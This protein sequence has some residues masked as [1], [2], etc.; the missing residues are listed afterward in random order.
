[1]WVHPI[2]FKSDAFSTFQ[3]FQAR[4]ENETGHTIQNGR[5]KRLNETILTGM[6]CMLIEAG[7]S[8]KWWAEAAL[9]YAYIKNQSPHSAIGDAVPEHMYT[10][11]PPDVSHLRVFGCAA[12]VTILR[13]ARHKLEAPGVKMVHLGRNDKHKG[14][15]FWDP[16]TGKVHVTCDVHQWDEDK[17]PLKVEGACVPVLPLTAKL[18]GPNPVLARPLNAAAPAPA[19]T[20]TPL[21]SLTPDQT[22]AP[23]P[24]SHSPAAPPRRPRTES[25]SSDGS[26][27]VLSPTHAPRARPAEPVTPS[28]SPSMSPAP[29]DESPDPLM[30]STA[31]AD[32]AHNDTD[33]SG[34]AQAGDP[35]NYTEAMRSDLAGQWQQCADDKF[36][37]LRDKFNVFQT[38]DACS[39]PPTAKLLGSKWV[40]KTKPDETGS[41]TKYKARLV[42]LGCHQRN[43]IDYKETFALVAQFASICLLIAL[44]ASQGWPIIQADVDKA[45]LHGDLDKDLYLRIPQGVHGLQGKVLKLQRSLYGHSLATNASIVVGT[46]LYYIALYVDNLL[47]IGPDRPHI[48]RVLDG[49]E[50]EYGIKRLGDAKYILGIQVLRGVDGSV[51]LSQ[52]AYANSL[53]ERFQM[54][55]AHPTRIPMDAGLKLAQA[56]CPINP[57]VETEYRQMVGLLGYLAMGTRGEI[58]HAVGY[59]GRFFTCCNE[60]H[61]TAARHVL[62]Y[63]HGTRNL[64]LVYGGPGTPLELTGFS[65]STWLD[66]PLTS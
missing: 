23:S 21:P 3:H 40:F 15:R 57:K 46:E 24:D 27:N 49:L 19:A 37:S 16:R 59:L 52:R 58:A 8:P 39:L 38:I 25:F 66:D 9:T 5:A 55:Q 43:G 53:L 17:F 34:Y 50:R 6:R 33:K 62:K 2:W 20:H 7:L 51:A 12:W 44:A 4:V 47:F 31:V 28:P 30:L 14:W 26:S 18:H 11:T 29:L 10:G 45:Y 61:I 1:M 32:N 35:R 65:D 42:A 22:P 63:I 56:Q 54:T 36:T 48:E 13:H 60:T 64:V 41:V